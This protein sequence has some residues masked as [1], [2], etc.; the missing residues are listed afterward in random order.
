MVPTHIQ[1]EERDCERQ[2]PVLS[3]ACTTN[4][5]SSTELSPLEVI[6]AV[7]PDSPRYPNMVSHAAA[8]GW[9]RVPDAPG[10]LIHH[11]V[12]DC[13]LDKRGEGFL[14]RGHQLQTEPRSPPKTN[15]PG[16]GTRRI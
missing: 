16:R 11:C 8:F 9:L 4:S 12:V 10:N 15:S 14:F 3:L 6:I 1:T 7:I 2:L 13:I 5:H